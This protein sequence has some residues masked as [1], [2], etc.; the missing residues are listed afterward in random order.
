VSAESHAATIFRHQHYPGR[1]NLAGQQLGSIARPIQWKKAWPA[2]D[3]QLLHA[4]D[5]SRAWNAQAGRGAVP[6]ADSPIGFFQNSQDVRALDIRQCLGRCGHSRLH[7]KFELGG[8]GR[9]HAALGHNY[10]ALNEILQ[11]ATAERP[12][13]K[14]PGPLPAKRQLMIMA[15][16]KLEDSALRGRPTITAIPQA[17]TGAHN[18]VAKRSYSWAI[19]SDT[20]Q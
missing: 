19:D 4:A 8:S 15:S 12:T 6:S 3:S 18:D 7:Q 16:T 20:P 14:S 17:I 9:Q 10:R 2:R 11:L 13:A 1:I 5:E